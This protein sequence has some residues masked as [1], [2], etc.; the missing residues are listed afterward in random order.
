MMAENTVTVG[1]LARF[2]AKPG[3]EAEVERF[4]LR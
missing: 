2:E 4:F 3:H 1:A